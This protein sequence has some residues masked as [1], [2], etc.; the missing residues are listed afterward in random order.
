MHESKDRCYICRSTKYLQKQ[1]RYL[2][3]KTGEIRIRYMCRKCNTARC[4]LYR[5]TANGNQKMREAVARS[6]KKYPEKQN[7]RIKLNNAISLGKIERPR[8]CSVCKT[9]TKIQAHHS[10]YAQ[11]FDV[12][13]CC[14]NCHREIDKFSFLSTVAFSVF[15]SNL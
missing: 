11:P 10:D 9:K 15:Q 8:H 6:I 7:A 4:M 13:W 14:R 1:C 2:L 3:K 5:K 12:V